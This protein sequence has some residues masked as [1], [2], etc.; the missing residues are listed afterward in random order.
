MP[1]GKFVDLTERIFGHVEVLYRNG[2]KVYLC[3]SGKVTK[4]LW[5]CRCNGKG[6]KCKKTF[7]TD[8]GHLLGDRVNSCGCL[9]SYKTTSPYTYLFGA[10]RGKAKVAGREF[11]LSKEYFIQLIKAACY[12]CGLPPVQKLTTVL[13]AHSDFLYNGIDRIDS[14]KGYIEG[15]VVS[16]CKICNEMKMDRSQVEFLQ[17]VEAIYAWQQKHLKT[18]AAG[19]SA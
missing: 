7:T 13:P 8:S 19:S 14:S 12:Y 10:Y 11:S 17:Q 1:T 18:M 4:P 15:N 9:R 3:P 5:F 16:C 2:T 6:R